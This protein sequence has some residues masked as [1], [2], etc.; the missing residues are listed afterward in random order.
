[1]FT[2]KYETIFENGTK[3]DNTISGSSFINYFR[4][5]EICMKKVPI[6]QA[7]E[8]DIE[9]IHFDDSDFIKLL[10]LRKSIDKDI[11]VNL[12]IPYLPYS[13]MDREND[14]YVFTLKYVC[15]FINDLNFNKVFV[16]DAH[17]DV[18]LGI[19]NNCKSVN[20][21]DKIEKFLNKEDIIIFPDVGAE[22][23]YK[24]QYK[25]YP[26]TI[27]ASKQRDFKTGNITN[28][29]LNY[30]DSID[31]SKNIII[32]D[33]ICSKGGTFILLAN[34]LIE[35]GFIGLITLIVSYCEDTIKQGEV[36][37]GDQISRVITSH[38]WYLEDENRVTLI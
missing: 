16:T 12:I 6:T 3:I 10:F 14:D 15:E 4:N 18:C 1:M 19:L 23:R 13:R 7:K 28:L 30:S 17:S 2:V 35:Q 9:W 34:K 5:G 31:K 20:F 36:L 24:H 38:A 22:K 37:K 29:T 32:V 26:F 21:K 27:T 11:K 25:D 8:V 33:D